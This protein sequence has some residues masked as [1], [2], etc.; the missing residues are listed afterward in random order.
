M[1]LTWSVESVIL[2]MWALALASVNPN[3]FHT[4]VARC[5]LIL[6]GFTLVAQLIVSARVLPVAHAISEAFA[7][8]VF[9]LLAMYL[10]VLL[11]S[12]NY[13]DPRLFSFSV[14]GQFVPLDGC[15]GIGW[16]CTA[17]ISVLGMALSERGRPTKLM[18]HPFG[19]HMLIVPPS[20][21]VFWLYNYNATA[22]D[23]VSQTMHMFAVAGHFV[24]ALVLIGLWGVFILLQ[25]TGEWIQ[26]PNTANDERITLRYVTAMAIKIMGSAACIVIPVSA[27]FS[28]RTNAQAI[29]FWVFIGVGVAN[30]YDWLQ[31]VDWVFRKTS[32]S[33]HQEFVAPLQPSDGITSRMDPAALMLHFKE[34]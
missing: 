9:G 5:H 23:P 22:T 29:L 3:P 34:F 17:I 25:A 30:T 15:V 8:A 20:F 16:F 11:D 27:L 7:C 31:I 21:L 10:T 1:T 32:S 24:Y 33:S 28:V 12:K 14:L 4:F 26:W 19:Y 13:S 2:G 18:L 6:S